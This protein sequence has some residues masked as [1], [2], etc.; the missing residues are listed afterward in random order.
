MLFDR[1]KDFFASMGEAADNEPETPKD[2][3]KLAAA[4]LF[5]YLIAADGV[6][7]DAESTRLKELLASEFDISM[8][9]AA[10]LY[11]EGQSASQTSVDLYG[12]TSTLKQKLDQEQRIALIEVLWELAYADGERHQE[13]DHLIWRMSDLMGI[14][15]RE[16]ILA[17]QRVEAD[18]KTR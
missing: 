18:M 12:F 1:L 6:V 10:A 5:N 4:A 16:R 17:R 8:D 11:E 7:D 9:E 15:G 14:S 13:E 3:P 2:D